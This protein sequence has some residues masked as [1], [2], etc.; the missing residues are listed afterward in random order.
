MA[1]APRRAPGQR[2]K[3]SWLPCKRYV[4][5]L[6]RQESADIA[7]AQKQPTAE[8]EYQKKKANFMT[9][10]FWTFSM[11]AL[12]FTAL[13]IGHIYIIAV[14][15]AIQIVC[16]KE[17]IAIAT[18]PSRARSIRATKSLNWY[19]LAST[20]YFLYGESVIYY[21]KHVVLVD[22][23]LLP[24]ATHHRFISFILYVFGQL[25]SPYSSPSR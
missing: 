20:M 21:F 5:S 25:H 10:T 24:L 16:F 12:F 18:V 7:D 15:T 14:I 9:R 3:P 17:I 19:W 23:M 4:G 8:E 11:L 22:K 6:R 1:L 2:P 13:F